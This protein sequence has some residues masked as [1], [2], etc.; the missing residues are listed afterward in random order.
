MDAL[1]SE[2]QASLTLFFHYCVR[3]TF[4]LY[5]KQHNIFS[6]VKSKLSNSSSPTSYW[7]V[8]DPYSGE[9]QKWLCEQISVYVSQNFPESQDFGEKSNNNFIKHTEDFLYMDLGFMEKGPASL[10]DVLC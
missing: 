4:I 9:R 10:P 5:W 6:I 1:M 7:Q 8:P 3:D 2:V